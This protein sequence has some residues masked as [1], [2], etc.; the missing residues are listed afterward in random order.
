MAIAS[1]IVPAAVAS[2][3]IVTQSAIDRPSVR[4]KGN[5]PLPTERRGRMRTGARVAAA[6]LAVLSACA[7]E[8]PPAG[9]GDVPTVARV[10]C[11]EGGTRVETP[12]VRPQADGVHVVIDNRLA[13][14][15]GFSTQYENGAG[16]GSNAP[17]GESRHVIPAPP[18]ALLIGCYTDRD[19]IESDL[20]TLDVVDP[21]DIYRSTELDCDSIVGGVS[22]YPEGA[23]GERGD[24]VDLATA[25]F[26]QV[27]DLGDA[28]IVE[29]AGYPQE[30]LRTVRLVRDGRVV[31]TISFYGS[32]RDGWLEDTFSRC[33]ELDA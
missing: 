29:L 32:E 28:D 30:E 11:A 23:T 26:D 15:T 12:S 1:T 6:T 33:K 8:A 31:A 18:G 4:E 5:P 16:G 22:D 3:E 19:A 25:R 27:T 17:M 13:F 21:S 9:D 14:D 20:Q 7:R 24:P 2:A 10:V